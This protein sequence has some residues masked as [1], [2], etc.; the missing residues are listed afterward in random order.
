MKLIPTPVVDAFAKGDV[1]PVLLFA[2]L[3]GCALAL[4]GEKG[5]KITGLVDDL[6]HALFKVMG[7]RHRQRAGPCGVGW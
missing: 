1:L 3:F 7:R 2:V 6:G 4:L 5:A